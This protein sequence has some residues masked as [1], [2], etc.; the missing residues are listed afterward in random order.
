MTK[1]YDIP[2]FTRY[3]VLLVDDESAPDNIVVDED[4]EFITVK[5]LRVALTA[6]IETITD[7]GNQFG[8]D[9]DD[10]MVRQFM[11]KCA[12]KAATAKY[13]LDMIGGK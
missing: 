3:N 13:F 1:K 5:Q 8:D 6:Y 12:A 9:E 7:Q 4:G 10:P 11:D 2:K